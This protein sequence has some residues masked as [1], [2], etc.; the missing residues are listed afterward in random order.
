M[1]VVVIARMVGIRMVFLRIDDADDDGEQTESVA[2]GLA[3]CS[4]SSE[5]E[6]TVGEMRWGILKETQW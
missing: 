6:M 3:K 2:G 4:E 1:V 5:T